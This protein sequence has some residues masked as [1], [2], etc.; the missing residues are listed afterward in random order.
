MQ[1]LDIYVVSFLP[2]WTTWRVRMEQLNFCLSNCR[3]CRQS[4]PTETA[5]RSYQTSLSKRLGANLVRFETGNWYE[6]QELRCDVWT[7]CACMLLACSTG[8]PHGPYKV[9]YVNGSSRIVHG[10]PNTTRIV[11]GSLSPQAS[12]PCGLKNWFSP[13]VLY[14]FIYLFV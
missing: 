10:L 8:Y 2:S 7:R 11:T 12:V 4:M 9:L 6:Q 3:V 14:L 13:E 1:Q 5:R